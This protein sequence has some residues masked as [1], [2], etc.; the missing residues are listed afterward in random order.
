MSHKLNELLYVNMNNFESVFVFN[1][2]N[3]CSLSILEIKM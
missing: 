3:I 1:L 2:V